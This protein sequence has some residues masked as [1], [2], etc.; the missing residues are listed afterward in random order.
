MGRARRSVTPDIVAQYD[1]FSAKSKA[2]WVAGEDDTAY[3]MDK[4]AEEQARED[5]LLAG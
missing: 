2:K 5:A 3:D 1:E 4:A